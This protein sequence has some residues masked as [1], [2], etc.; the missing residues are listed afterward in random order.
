MNKEPIIF[1]CEDSLWQMMKGGEKTFDMRR[2]DIADE[3]I[4]RLSWHKATTPDASS[5]T[6]K[7]MAQEQHWVKY[8]TR[9]EPEECHVAFLNKVTGEILTF[10]YLGV[11]FAPWAPGWGFII[12]G[13]RI[14][15]KAAGGAG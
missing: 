5:R 15:A 13:K 7:D 10:E 14:E 1:K 8:N 9:W 4:Y 11:E 6:M 2:W 3:R 12:L